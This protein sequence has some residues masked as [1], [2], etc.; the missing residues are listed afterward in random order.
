MEAWGKMVRSQERATTMVLPIRRFAGPGRAGTLLTLAA[1]LLGAAAA[2]AQTTDLLDRTQRLQEVA[3]R[4]VE[5]EARLTLK[6]A[7]RLERSDPAQAA[8]KLKELLTEHLRGFREVFGQG[9]S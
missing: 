3:T 4:Q 2:P 8:T 6:E 1:G 5:A 7:S 9:A